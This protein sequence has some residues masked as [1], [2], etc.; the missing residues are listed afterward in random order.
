MAGQDLFVVEVTTVGNHVELA[1]LE[2]RLGLLG[3]DGEPGAVV[4]HIGHLV[5]DDQVV[6]GVD[7]RLHIVANHAVAP[8][9]GGHGVGV[10]IGQRDSIRPHVFTQPGP[11][12]AIGDTE[13]S[14]EFAQ[15]LL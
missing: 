3:H 14:V 4:A 1:G 9:T 11:E 10:G 8:A 12:A 6:F 5:G 2:S 7:R 15:L 13:M